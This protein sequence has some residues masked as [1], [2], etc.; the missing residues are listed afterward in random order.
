MVSLI[1][2][3]IVGEVSISSIGSKYPRVMNEKLPLLAALLKENAAAVKSANCDGYIYSYPLH[4]AKP[5]AVIEPV[6][7]KKFG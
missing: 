4:Y 6:H 3:E 2:S 5:Q 1:S 7:R